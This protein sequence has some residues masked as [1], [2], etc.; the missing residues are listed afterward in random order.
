MKHHIVH[1]SAN[2]V[3]Q[4]P[5]V[6]QREMAQFVR[7]EKRNLNPSVEHRPA[8]LSEVRRIS[9]ARTVSGLNDELS[10]GRRVLLATLFSGNWHKR[11][12]QA[13]YLIGHLDAS[14]R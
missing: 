3:P 1:K 7:E 14:C 13:R 5:K 2:K 4:I 6:T 11:E 9:E 10:K 12:V 8:V